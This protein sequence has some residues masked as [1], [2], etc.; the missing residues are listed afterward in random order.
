M[1]G[2]AWRRHNVE[3]KECGIIRPTWPDSH[4]TLSERTQDEGNEGGHEEEQ[5]IWKRKG[6]WRKK[7]KK[8]EEK[9]L[10]HV[11]AV[12]TFVSLHFYNSNMP[13]VVLTGKRLLFSFFFLLFTWLIFHGQMFRSDEWNEFLFR[14][15][16]LAKEWKRREGGLIVLEFWVWEP[17]ANRRAGG[18]EEGQGRTNYLRLVARSY[19]YRKMRGSGTEGCKDWTRDSPG[20]LEV[21]HGSSCSRWALWPRVG[22]VQSVHK[23]TC[24]S[25]ICGA[26]VG[27]PLSSA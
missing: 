8:E 17:T 11:T 15:S 9:A 1:L 12:A 6:R 5:D 24:C 3:E 27:R 7:E 22:G 20:K 25:R 10:G 21:Q 4:P 14:L 23:T 18:S 2:G 19:I 16:S 13:S 26:S